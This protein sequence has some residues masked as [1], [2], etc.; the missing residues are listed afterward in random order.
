MNSNKAKRKNC[1]QEQPHEDNSC[2]KF[3]C[4]IE[5]KKDYEHKEKGDEN[6]IIKRNYKYHGVYRNFHPTLNDWGIK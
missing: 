2:Y 6:E 3:F 5:C 4:D 1:G